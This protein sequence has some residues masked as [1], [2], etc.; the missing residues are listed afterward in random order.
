MFQNECDTKELIIYLIYE[1]LFSNVIFFRFFIVNKNINGSI[2][3][4]KKYFVALDHLNR[5]Q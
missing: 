4:K 3:L 1:I 2:F 5:K